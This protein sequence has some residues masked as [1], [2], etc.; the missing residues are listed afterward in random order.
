MQKNSFVSSAT[1]SISAF[2]NKLPSNPLPNVNNVPTIS[3]FIDELVNGFILKPAD[4]QQDDFMSPLVFSTISQT[5][6]ELKTEKT[7]HILEDLT[8]VS[9]HA[10]NEPIKISLKGYN[11][12]ESSCAIV[13]LMTGRSK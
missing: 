11:S 4:G 10:I 1:N 2:K 9:D 5:T 13:L 3:G 12:S 6:I 8:V 7:N